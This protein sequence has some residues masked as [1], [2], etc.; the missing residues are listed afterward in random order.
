MLLGQVVKDNVVR[1][2]DLYSP[3][4]DTVKNA[5]NSSVAEVV[6]RLSIAGAV[7]ARGHGSSGKQTDLDAVTAQQ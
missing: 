6:R 4:R 7:F 3:G 1:V 2:T 5:G